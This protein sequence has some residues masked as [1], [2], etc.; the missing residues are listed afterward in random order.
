MGPEREEIRKKFTTLQ[1]KI[2]KL[3]AASQESITVRLEEWIRSPTLDRG[4]ALEKLNKLVESKIWE[5]SSDKS[6]L[7]K[8][9]VEILNAYSKTYQRDQLFAN[10][11]YLIQSEPGNEVK[12]EEIIKNYA[13]IL[14]TIRALVTEDSNNKWKMD[15]AFTYLGAFFGSD[16]WRKSDN[17]LYLL[18][19]YGKILEYFLKD[20][21]LNGRVFSRDFITSIRS[22]EFGHYDR[23]D[24]L[25][26]NI[27]GILANKPGLM[28]NEARDPNEEL[29]LLFSNGGFEAMAEVVGK[30]ISRRDSI[31]AALKAWQKENT[32]TGEGRPDTFSLGMGEFFNEN[33]HFEA[34]FAAEGNVAQWRKWFKD[35]QAL[36]AKAYRDDNGVSISDFAEERLA[37]RFDPAKK[38]GQ[39]NDGQ[40]RILVDYSLHAQIMVLE[41]LVRD[42]I[43]RLLFIEA[44]A[45]EAKNEAA[46]QSAKDKAV[47]EW[48][49]YKQSLSS[50]KTLL[51]ENSSGVPL[52]SGIGGF[53]RDEKQLVRLERFMIEQEGEDY[54]LA[55]IP[56]LSRH[57]IGLVHGIGFSR[58]Y[59]PDIARANGVDYSLLVLYLLSAFKTYTAAVASQN[60]A[61]AAQVLT[62]IFQGLNTD[63]SVLLHVRDELMRMK[64]KGAASAY[65]TA[66]PQ[67]VLDEETEVKKYENF[68]NSLAGELADKFEQSMPESPT[69]ESKWLNPFQG[70]ETTLGTSRMDWSLS[71]Q[72]AILVTAIK[73][74]EYKKLGLREFH[75]L[76]KEDFL[77]KIAGTNDLDKLKKRQAWFKEVLENFKFFSYEY[78]QVSFGNEPSPRHDLE[79]AQKLVRGTLVRLREMRRSEMRKSG[80][81]QRSAISVQPTEGAARSEARGAL[82]VQKDLP[83]YLAGVAQAHD[84]FRYFMD[85][86]DL[87]RAQQD[88]LLQQIDLEF[89]TGG[90]SYAL[91][92]LIRID[93]TTKVS[94]AITHSLSH[95]FGHSLHSYFGFVRGK[96]NLGIMEAYAVI[97][98]IVADMKSGVFNARDFE[99]EAAIGEL[100]FDYMDARKLSWEQLNEIRSDRKGQEKFIE[101]L[102]AYAATRSVV[103]G[104]TFK[105][106]MIAMAFDADY[107]FFHYVGYAIVR[108]VFKGLGTDAQSLKT[109]QAEAAAKIFFSALTGKNS[110][111]I[112]FLNPENFVE[113]LLE[114]AAKNSLH[115]VSLGL[116]A[117]LLKTIQR[118]WKGWFSPKKRAF[119]LFDLQDRVEWVDVSSDT[120]DGMP[121]AIRNLQTAEKAVVEAVAQRE[122]FIRQVEQMLRKDTANADG[123]AKQGEAISNLGVLQPL[124]KE[125]FG[126]IRFGFLDR[127]KLML[128]KYLIKSGEAYPVNAFNPAVIS[129]HSKI[130]EKSGQTQPRSDTPDVLLLKPGR[131]WS[132]T[133]VMGAIAAVLFLVRTNIAENAA[134]PAASVAQTVQP[135]SSTVKEL[136]QSQKIQDLL[137]KLN[138]FTEAN[139]EKEK[140]NLNLEAL[141]KAEQIALIYVMIDRNNTLVKTDLAQAKIF[142]KVTTHVWGDLTKT[143]NGLSPLVKIAL[144]DNEPEENRVLALEQIMHWLSHA[145]VQSREI[146]KTLREKLAPLGSEENKNDR[147]HIPAKSILKE[148]KKLLEQNSPTD[149]RYPLRNYAVGDMKHLLIGS[150]AAL[151]PSSVALVRSEMRLLQKLGFKDKFG[152]RNL[153]TA[154]FLGA[155]PI[156]GVLAGLSQFVIWTSPIV[157]Y[158]FVSAAINFILGKPQDQAP[159]SFRSFLRYLFDPAARFKKPIIRT[160]TRVALIGTLWL[161][162]KYAFSFSRANDWKGKIDNYLNKHGAAATLLDLGGKLRNVPGAERVIEWSFNRMAHAD[163]EFEKELARHTYEQM[164]TAAPFV[165]KSVLIFSWDGPPII[166]NSGLVSSGDHKSISSAEKIRENWFVVQMGGDIIFVNSNADILITKI[167]QALRKRGI[168]IE[169][170]G[171]VFESMS[172]YGRVLQMGSD[173]IRFSVKGAGIFKVYLKTNGEI[174]ILSYRSEMRTPKA[175]DGVS[176]VTQRSENRAEYFFEGVQVDSAKSTARTTVISIA[177]NQNPATLQKLLSNLM[178][179]EMLLEQNSKATV[180]MNAVTGKAETLTMSV[181]TDKTNYKP[182][183]WAFVDAPMASTEADLNHVRRDDLDVSSVLKNGILSLAFLFPRSEMRGWGDELQTLVTSTERSTLVDIDAQ[184]V[185]QAWVINL[186]RA[187]EEMRIPFSILQP[188]APQGDDD[189]LLRIIVPEFLYEIKLSV[190][191]GNQIHLTAMPVFGTPTGHAELHGA[192]TARQIKKSV[193]FR[194]QASSAD[195]SVQRPQVIFGMQSFDAADLTLIRE[196]SDDIKVGLVEIRL[197]G[198]NVVI[199]NLGNNPSGIYLP[200]LQ[201]RALLSSPRS[202]A[203]W[204]DHFDHQRDPKTQPLDYDQAQMYWQ[205]FQRGTR[206]P[207]GMWTFKETAKNVVLA[208]LDGT[209]TG[210]DGGIGFREARKL[211]RSNI[212]EDK[213]KGMQRMVMLYRKYVIG[214]KGTKKKP[215]KA[216]GNQKTEDGQQSFFYEVGGLKTLMVQGGITKGYL[217]KT[218]SPAELIRL[219][220]PELIDVRNPDALD[221]LEVE[222]NYWTD[223]R[224][225]IYHLQLALETIPEFARVLQSEKFRTAKKIDASEVSGLA[226]AYRKNVLEAVGGQ[227]KFFET[228]GGMTGMF[229][230]L[231][232]KQTAFDEIFSLAVPGLVDEKNSDALQ[233]HELVETRPKF[234]TVDYIVGQVERVFDHDIPGF[235]AARAAG[236]DQRMA[237]FIQ[238]SE[239]LDEGEKSLRR[240]FE[241]HRLGRFLWA[242]DSNQISFIG[243]SANPYNLVEF[244]FPGILALTEK[245][246]APKKGARSKKP[247]SWNKNNIIGQ[248]LSK[249]NS[250]HGFADALSAHDVGSMVSIYRAQLLHD[251]DAQVAFFKDL[252]LNDWLTQ[253]GKEMTDMEVYGL[254]RL[255]VPEMFDQTKFA[256]ALTLAE[257]T[258]AANRS[259]AR[260]SSPKETFSGQTH[261]ERIPAVVKTPIARSELHVV[262]K[263][264]VGFYENPGSKDVVALGNEVSTVHDLILFSIILRQEVM[265]RTADSSGILAMQSHDF[266]N[267]FSI[268]STRANSSALAELMTGSD[269]VQIASALTLLSDAEAKAFVEHW[270]KLKQQLSGVYFN[271]AIL[272]K[273]RAI[274]QRLFGKNSGMNVLNYQL[275]TLPKKVPILVDGETGP[276]G[277]DF[278]G[279]K[280]RSSDPRVEDMAM[281]V[282]LISAIVKVR[283]N[284]N[285]EEAVIAINHIL[286]MSGKHVFDVVS[287][288]EQG[289]FFANINQLEQ[290]IGAM[291]EANQAVQKAA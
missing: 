82:K 210:D 21:L 56:S 3:E 42:R 131:L 18:R 17:K 109:G 186:I 128:I 70:D 254:I 60:D 232:R 116:G 269:S 67:E 38:D 217:L 273:I 141:S 40:L 92:K 235:S 215:T 195:L 274:I 36:R 27:V 66:F 101:D 45:K 200:V 48:K 245:S 241:T 64:S 277:Y 258:S 32:P 179:R 78:P 165:S 257:V 43:S 54:A 20:T 285:R 110:E 130:Q 214:Y 262:A 220:I 259:E 276:A 142:R 81:D 119:V 111:A 144:G 69:G 44:E 287:V 244:V 185:S 183:T 2:E 221:P 88:A 252:I 230:E 22:G 234:L 242:A 103:I 164:L 152:T 75:A 156:I 238:E 137:T 85:L 196:T 91:G 219:A 52:G 157:V 187:P 134:V 31:F 272:G 145:K 117:L 207:Y 201:F 249:L 53:D 178:G 175:Q 190:T 50:L 146:L 279:Q 46:A 281:F 87:P 8:S 191:P 250:L 184:A 122:R 180:V 240:F 226:Q 166:V 147:T 174:D 102:I 124:I 51:G 10:L 151:L 118:I 99:T 155:L 153:F 123:Q 202:E 227:A 125:E 159:D 126:F 13:E 216:E 7:I 15:F 188:L 57:L 197:E 154:V 204:D 222:H 61:R 16:G 108:R 208:I 181:T 212:A 161:V 6:G 283:G 239:I 77:G 225:K 89:T 35:F 121:R 29:E 115:L 49:Q 267:V 177:Q 213:K 135:Q 263:D 228:D 160:I 11:D 94:S 105:N 162:A 140:K 112:D 90:G 223:D 199:K 224:N 133:G 37:S 167:L 79:I 34:F 68:L 58:T 255:A 33:K 248:T 93:G 55:L 205:D 194:A 96:M 192:G 129:A 23:D 59:Q 284:K 5:Q 246:A 275:K 74:P 268:L 265:A 170:Q 271:A 171:I 264:V 24:G 229:V 71:I 39:L 189:T 19:A 73:N 172:S 203:R 198:D 261:A 206:Y 30:M 280:G 231:V 150:I 282:K 291:F 136:A 148:I 209:L 278:V 139:I 143:S 72:M 80:S 4:V 247:F 25:E 290:W 65:V 100:L 211:L 253:S 120:R 114:Q 104:E 173:G 169:A 132:W 163:Y 14:R 251:K 62:V 286:F 97:L 236:D 168:K 41:R 12:H 288:D 63:S 9:F 260:S 47:R 84:L 218:G 266:D 95:E 98:E 28:E 237:E 138:A 26:L 176:G 193:P 233:P 107:G 182:L 1:E 149:R 83:G 113:N 270:F 86:I 243:N 106:K 158:F 127:I 76:N 256:G 289:H